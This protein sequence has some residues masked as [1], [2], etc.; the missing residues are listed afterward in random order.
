MRVDG[1]DYSKARLDEVLK[2]ALV[3]ILLHHLLVVEVLHQ[4][5]EAKEV[6]LAHKAASVSLLKCKV[7]ID[8]LHSLRLDD[9]LLVQLVEHLRSHDSLVFY[10][11]DLV[12]DLSE[13]KHSS[14]DIY[15]AFC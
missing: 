10:R 14:S 7:H 13:I 4:M 8:L 9:L 3:A 11:S 5:A 15:S 1:L 6:D 2:R 12:E